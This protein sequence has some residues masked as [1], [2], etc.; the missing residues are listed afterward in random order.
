MQIKKFTQQLGKI[1][2]ELEAIRKE[3]S[4]ET[5][6][7]ATFPESRRSLI[8][9]KICLACGEPLNNEK[10]TRKCHYRCYKQLNQ[11]VSAGASWD[12]L[13]SAG[14]CYYAGSG[15]R[16]VGRKP[17]DQQAKSKEVPEKRSAKKKS[18]TD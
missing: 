15:G 16:P 12:D 8:D 11:E 9:R 10:Q 7:E 14:R 4:I 2:S 3:M 18:E 13:I 1:I 6:E 17:S 5:S